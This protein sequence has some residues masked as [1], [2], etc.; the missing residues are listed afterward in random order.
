MILNPPLWIN[1]RDAVYGLGHE[2]VSVSATYIDFDHLIDI[3]SNQTA[4]ST[5]VTFPDIKVELDDYYYATINED[6]P[7][8]QATFSDQL[9]GFDSVWVTEYSPDRIRV[10]P[11]GWVQNNTD[12]GADHQPESHLARFGEALFLTDIQITQEDTELQITLD[13]QLMEPMPDVTIFRHIVSCSNEMIAQGD[14]LAVGRT[15]P[16]DNT[17]GVT[18]VR[19]I[20]TFTLAD[21]VPKECRRVYVGLFRP[22]GS[23]VAAVDNNG[24]PLGDNAFSIDIESAE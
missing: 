9:A 5:A 4:D 24:H 1:Y 7:W 12:T 19:D 11:V 18:K 13:W 14:G 6:S 15:F 23:R 2:G 16:F 21:D 10:V 8:T 3:N 17:I 20:R 22:D